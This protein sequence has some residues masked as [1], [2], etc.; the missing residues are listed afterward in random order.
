M[1]YVLDFEVLGKCP[2]KIIYET[3][4]PLIVAQ[5]AQFRCIQTE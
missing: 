5:S 2:P 4:E 3:F 1:A